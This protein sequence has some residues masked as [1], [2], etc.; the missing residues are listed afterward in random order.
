[1]LYQLSYK[2]IVCCFAGAK[3]RSLFYS[4]KLFADFFYFDHHFSLFRPVF[5]S[6]AAVFMP[7]KTEADRLA[8]IG[9]YGLQAPVMP[10]AF[11]GFML[12]YGLYYSMVQAVWACD[13]GRFAKPNRAFRNMLCNRGSCKALDFPKLLYNDCVMPSQSACV[14]P[15]LC[16]VCFGRGFAAMR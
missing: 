8:C 13:S 12:Q 11:G 2:R 3:V 1:M 6:L 14:G 7:D 5:C 16:R 4:T 9:K 15:A 10:V